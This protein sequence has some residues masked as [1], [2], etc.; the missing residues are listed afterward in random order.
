MPDKSQLDS[1]PKSL[2]AIW[3]LSNDIYPE[4][5]EK[6]RHAEEELDL[7][8]KRDKAAQSVLG[9]LLALVSGRANRESCGH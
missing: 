2:D 1:E 7:Q 6:Q 8:K 9:R 5:L 4:L 3:D